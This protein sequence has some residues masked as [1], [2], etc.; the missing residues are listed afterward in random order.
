MGA[1]EEKWE[2][3]LRRI[4][5]VRVYEEEEWCEGVGGRGGEEEGVEG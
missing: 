1:W 4:S 3:R 5:C 2:C